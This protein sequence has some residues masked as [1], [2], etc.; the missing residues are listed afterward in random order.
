MNSLVIQRFWAKTAISDTLAFN[1]TPCRIWTGAQVDRTRPNPYGRYCAKGRWWVAHQFAYV[2]THGEIPTG[3]EIDHLCCRSLCVEPTHLEAVT[4]CENMRR[5]QRNRTYSLTCPQGHLRTRYN[6]QFVN[7]QWGTRQCAVCNRDR[8]REWVR[9]H[10]DKPMAKRSLEDLTAECR[11][12]HRRTKANTR[13]TKTGLVV[14][15]T[16]HVDA[17]TRWKAKKTA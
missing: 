8:V 1:G 7:N 4:R 6:I 15:Q 17:V 13:F 16:C 12:G 11:N 10:T 5:A 2:L 9:K 3:L 14:C